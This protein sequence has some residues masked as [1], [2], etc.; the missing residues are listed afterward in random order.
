MPYCWGCHGSLNQFRANIANGMLAGNVCTHNNPRPDVTASTARR[1]SA[2]PGASPPISRP[3]LFRAL[4]TQLQNA[5]DLQPGDALNKPGSHVMLFLR[6]TPDRKAEVM[7][8]STG[9]CNG[10]VC[11]NVYPLSSLLARGYRPVR[12][13]ALENAPVADARDA[14]DLVQQSK[15]GQTEQ[16]EERHRADRRRH[17]RG[18][19][20]RSR[21]AR[22]N[23]PHGITR[24]IPQG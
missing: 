11:R 18:A 20:T 23:E 16:V 13:R 1:S 5:W 14:G 4:P 10:R 22:A 17:G 24:S 6:F 12:F 9:G 19:K 21:S 2:R 15:G 8:S 7:E 3:R